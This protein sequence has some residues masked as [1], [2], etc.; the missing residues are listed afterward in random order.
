MTGRPSKYKKEFVEQAVKLCKLG[1]TDIELA[2]FFEVNVATLYRWKNEYPDFCE[3]LKISKA[4]ADDRVERSL[5]ARANGYEHEEVDI[6]VV[7]GEIVQ[8]PI[9][10]FY[11]PDT[12]ACIFWLKNRRPE[13]WR[14]KVETELSGPNGGPLETKATLDVGSLSTEALAEIMALKD[15]AKPR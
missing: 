1:A 10:K 13:A 5:F 4:V 6:R 2:D 11:A 14:D 8:T 3:A 15:A 9:R 12:T 7:S